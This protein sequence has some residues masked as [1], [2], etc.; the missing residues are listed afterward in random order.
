MEYRAVN[1]TDPSNE[2][3]HWKYIRR[4]YD[5]NKG[6]YRYYYD[7]ATTEAAARTYESKYYI[8]GKE[9][10]T[11]GDK[12]KY[13]VQD[14][15]GVDEKKAYNTAKNTYEMEED[16]RRHYTDTKKDLVKDVDA[17]GE[18]TEL[19]QSWIDMTDSWIEPQKENVAEAK[20]L[21]DTV[22]ES[23]KK[24]PMYKIDQVGAAINNG[25]KKVKSLFKKLFGR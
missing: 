19:E 15:L 16:L 24:T 23:Y 21:V 11:I 6:R 4:E 18:R 9:K 5:H 14:A 13:G 3:T 12:I 10:L 20:K 17:D 8:G 25:K 7:D 22:L 2:L 1:K